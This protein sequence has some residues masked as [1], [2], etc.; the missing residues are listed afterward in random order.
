MNLFVTHYIHRTF[1]CLS[2]LRWLVNS[3]VIIGVVIRTL[4]RVIIFIEL[5]FSLAFSNVLK[6]LSCL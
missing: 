1:V 2:V 4:I 6:A 3:I 5:P